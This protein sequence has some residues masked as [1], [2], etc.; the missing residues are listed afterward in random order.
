MVSLFVLGTYRTPKETLVG[1]TIDLQH[2]LQSTFLIPKMTSFKTKWFH[3]ALV[4][5]RDSL[6]SKLTLKIARFKTRCLKNHLWRNGDGWVLK[7]AFK[8]L[9][10]K[11]VVFKTICGKME[12]AG[13][14]SSPSKIFI[15]NMLS[16]KPFVVKWRWLGFEARLQRSSFKTW[17]LQNHLW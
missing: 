15:Q 17:C 11:H 5:K 3:N 6:V 2:V 16:S 13:F 10:S 1:L 7:L 4:V 12:M 14:W 8:D 9:H